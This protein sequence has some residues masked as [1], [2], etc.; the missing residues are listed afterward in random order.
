MILLRADVRTKGLAWIT[1]L[2]FM[3]NV[4]VFWQEFRMNPPQLEHFVGHWGIIPHE[5]FNSFGTHAYTLISAMFLHGGWLHLFSNMLFLYIFGTSVEDQ[6]GHFKFL[7][8][9]FLVGVI[10]NGAQAYMVPQS[11]L[12]LIGASGAIAGILGAYFFYFPHSRIMTLIPLGIF[13]TI[14]EVPAFFFLGIWFL[15]QML[16][17]AFSNT[18]HIAGGIA[19]WAHAAGFMA[20]ILMAPM[21]GRK[22]GK[23]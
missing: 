7:F 9:Y 14:R 3:L 1:G 17:G 10:A 19:W 23:R 4:Y 15:L 13:I 21:F 20:G 22:I 18:L 11:H 8:F 5:L 16:N 12:P 2:L 6:F